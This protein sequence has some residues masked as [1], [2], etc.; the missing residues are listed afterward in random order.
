MYYF[1]RLSPTHRTSSSV[2]IV[3]YLDDKVSGLRPSDK[4]VVVK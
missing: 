1:V 3:H 4:E 2:S